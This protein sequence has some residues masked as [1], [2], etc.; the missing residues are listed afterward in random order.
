MNT[1]LLRLAT[2]QTTSGMVVHLDIGPYQFSSASFCL[3]ESKTL[4][5]LLQFVERDSCCGVWLVQNE[6][7][8]IGTLERQYGDVWHLSKAP[9]RSYHPIGTFHT[10]IEAILALSRELIRTGAL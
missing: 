2:L 5:T 1:E 8:V 6:R 7:G 9:L 10:P 3:V 4:K